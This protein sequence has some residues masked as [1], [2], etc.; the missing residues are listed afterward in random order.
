MP[1][2]VVISG[3]TGSSPFD[4]YLGD[5]TLKV[6]VYIDTITTTPYTF[7]IPFILDGL[8][9]YNLKVVDNTGCSI[10]EPFTP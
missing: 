8:P 2:N 7:E 1:N 9:S 10:I 5:N 3:I 6:V 4:I